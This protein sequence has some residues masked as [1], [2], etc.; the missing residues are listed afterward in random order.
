MSIRVGMHILLYNSVYYLII[1]I[2]LFLNTVHNKS[3]RDV[4]LRPGD[5]LRNIRWCK[6]EIAGNNTA[7]EPNILKFVRRSVV[8]LESK[9]CK[10]KIAS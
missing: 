2:K 6:V 9:I 10:R 4:N 8:A 1:C 3:I 5:I 7:F